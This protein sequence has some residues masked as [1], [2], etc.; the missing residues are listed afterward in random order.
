MP[1]KT[2]RLEFAGSEGAM[3]AARIDRPAGTPSGWALVA[4]CFTC[5]KDSLAAAR[6][7]RVLAEEGIGVLRFDFTGL[8]GS[9]G[10]FANTGFSSNIEDLAAAAGW[11][12]ENE[13]GPF[14]LVGHSLGG[15]AVLAAAPRI[16]SCRAVVTIGA[17]ADPSHI[18]RH[19]VR[20]AGEIEEE[21]EAEVE[22]GGRRFRIRESFLDD[23]DAQDL[24]G[25]L[26]DL[27]RALLILH[28]PDDEVVGVDHARRI[29][30]A[31]RHPKSLVSLDG[32][33]HLL[34]E[35]A[36]AEWA[37]RLVASW[38]RRYLPGES[39]EPV[40]GG[41]A[42]DRGDP[43]ELEDGWL[44]V[45]E[46]GEGKFHQIV[47]DGRHVLEADEPASYGG[48]DRGPSPYEL[49]IAG[50]GACTSMTIRM[51]A[52][53]KGWDLERVRVDLRHRK[54]H[55]EDCKHCQTQE[56]K[57]DRIERVV[58]LEGDLDEEQRG[59]LLEIADRCPVHRTLHE[60]V[61]VVTSE[62]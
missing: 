41:R 56:G 30:E 45:E 1:R 11:L 55:A 32:A 23:L 5:S 46:S 18:R 3:L 31:A 40:E 12:E 25:R 39:E 52:E 24:E 19:L 44:R 43:P 6:I 47:H 16:A 38:A 13:S 7:S 29:Y 49:V 58:H 15:A 4:H 10:D 17:P 9:G 59:R 27:D 33:D 8:G 42:A 50:L 22:I 36:I 57:L 54:I 34:T 53:R 35:R 37:A 26:A 28:A 21:G 51:V 48:D 14:L 2:E 20:A 60:E 62:G 61:D